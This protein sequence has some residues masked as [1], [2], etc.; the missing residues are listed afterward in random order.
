MLKRSRSAEER[1]RGAAA[2]HLADAFCRLA[3]R[4]INERFR[5]VFGNDD[6]AIYRTAQRVMADDFVW[7]EEGIV[8]RD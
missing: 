8:K 4:R 3:R 7:L 6:P 5:A 1:T 2:A